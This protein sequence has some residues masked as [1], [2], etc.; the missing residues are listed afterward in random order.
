MHQT[1]D[2]NQLIRRAQQWKL[3]RSSNEEQ[4]AS[5]ACDRVS[6]RDDAE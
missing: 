4:P 5:A 2:E 3:T 6:F 1:V